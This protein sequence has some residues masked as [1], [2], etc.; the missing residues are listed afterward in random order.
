MTFNLEFLLNE[1]A[2][3]NYPKNCIEYYKNK[4]RY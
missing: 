1:M 4:K 2:V 3:R